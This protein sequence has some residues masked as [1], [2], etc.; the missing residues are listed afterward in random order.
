MTISFDANGKP[1]VTTPSLV[2]TEGVTLKI[3]STTDLAD[4]SH[5][6]ERTLTVGGNGKQTFNHESD[7]QR[8]YKL[9]AE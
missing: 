1:V 9:K 7:P 2:R 8:F 5:P 3:L 4:W 6:E